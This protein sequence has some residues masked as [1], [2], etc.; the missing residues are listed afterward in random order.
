[1]TV[2]SEVTDTGKRIL[3]I[4]R[5]Y[6]KLYYGSA[7]ERLSNSYSY[8][9][10]IG[11]PEQCAT[12]HA[13]WSILDEYPD[14]NSVTQIID[15]EAYDCDCGTGE[16]YYEGCPIHDRK[17]GYFARLIKKRAAAILYEWEHNG[18]V[19][20]QLFCKQQELPI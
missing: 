18:N 5:K 9:Y 20:P 13:W 12:R 11:T 8:K 1:M 10:F 2:Y 15:G 19:W 16:R 3:R 7:G 6:R 17:E 4:R 14:P